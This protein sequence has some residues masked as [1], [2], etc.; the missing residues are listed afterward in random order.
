[1]EHKQAAADLWLTFIV[2]YFSIAVKWCHDQDNLNKKEFNSRAQS[3]RRLEFMAIVA[4]SKGI[5]R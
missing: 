1:M 4:V 5:G 3:S 2:V